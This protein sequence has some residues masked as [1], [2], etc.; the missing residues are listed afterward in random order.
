MLRDLQKL[1]KCH[2][3][4][5]SFFSQQALINPG[6]GVSLL[7]WPHPGLFLPGWAPGASPRLANTNWLSL[8][9]GLKKVVRA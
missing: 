3:Q 8:H 5:N 9:A 7:I 4:S 6:H 2:I 1:I